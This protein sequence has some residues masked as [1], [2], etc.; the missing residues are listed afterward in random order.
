MVSITNGVS[1]WYGPCYIPEIMTTTTNVENLRHHKSRYSLI[2]KQILAFTS[3]TN[4]IIV[5]I[6]V[7]GLSLN[8]RRIA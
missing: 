6:E 1:L 2:V 7:N 5:V 3:N 8:F 4:F